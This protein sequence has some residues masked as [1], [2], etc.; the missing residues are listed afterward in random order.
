MTRPT[1]RG[2]LQSAALL[3]LAGCSGRT[4]PATRQLT[5]F[6]Y[7]GLDKIFETHFA[8]PFRQKSGAAVILDA[9]W[10]DAVAKLKESP[11]G[12]P[13]YD[14]VLTDATQGYPAIK[15]GMFRQLDFAR[16]PNHTALAP[17]PST[18]GWRRSGT[19]S[20]STSRR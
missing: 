12:Q 20:R 8:E 6:V 15:S 1:R 13:T 10:W 11:K 18:T 4:T 2:F 3:P 9:G 7:S 17:S 16:I 19:A 14:L 5:V